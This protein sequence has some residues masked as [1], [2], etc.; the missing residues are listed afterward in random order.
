MY[1]INTTPRMQ[2]QGNYEINQACVIDLPSDVHM[3]CFR[4]AKPEV[5]AG[6]NMDSSGDYKV[7][8]LF[9]TKL[10]CQIIPG[11]LGG[12]GNCKIGCVFVPFDNK[13]NGTQ[14]L[15][16]KEDSTMRKG[17]AKLEI[18]SAPLKSANSFYTIETATVSATCFNTTGIQPVKIDTPS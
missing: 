15:I 16:L 1:Q 6:Y 9:A 17:F 10:T 3:N 7:N 5:S 13:I 8:L 14:F 2:V 11:T 18:I 4:L 12:G